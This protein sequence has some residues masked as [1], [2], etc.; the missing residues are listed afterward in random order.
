MAQARWFGGLVDR[1][2]FCSVKASFLAPDAY[3]WTLL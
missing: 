3:P 2:A 1:D